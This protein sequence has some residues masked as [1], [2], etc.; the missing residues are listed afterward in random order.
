MAQFAPL[1]QAIAICTHGDAVALEGFTHLIPYAAGHEII[2][3]GRSNLTLIPMTPDLKNTL[4]RDTYPY[5][6]S[7]VK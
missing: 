6:G 3:Q 2:R 5:L 4:C 7:D 1:Y